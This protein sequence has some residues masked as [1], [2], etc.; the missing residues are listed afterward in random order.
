[1][2]KLVNLIRLFDIY[3]N[4]FQ[5]RINNQTKFKTLYGGLLSLVTFIILILC[6]LSFG[7]DFF[8]R[9]NPKVTLEEG[10]FQDDEI[11][12]LTGGDYP[13]KPGLI[14]VQKSFAD[15]AKLKISGRI[16]G[17]L[18]YKYLDECEASYVQT[19][20]A[21]IKYSTLS[22]QVLYCF[23]FNEFSFYG[24]E[25]ISIS[26]DECS[27]KSVAEEMGKRNVTCNGNV[28]ATTASMYLTLYTKQLGFK[29][30]LEKPFINK[31]VLYNLNF[32]NNAYS[33]ALINWNLQYLHDDVGWLIDSINEITDLNPQPEKVSLLTYPQGFRLPRFVVQFKLKDQYKRYNRTYI[34]LQDVLASLGG[35]MKLILT[36]LNLTSMLIRS[37]LIDLYIIDEKF[38]LD[39]KPIKGSDDMITRNVGN[40]ENSHNSKLV[41]NFL[42][43]H[44]NYID[45]I[46]LKPIKVPEVKT[47]SNISIFRYYRAVMMNYL[48][49]KVIGRRVETSMGLLRKKLK[50]VNTFQDYSY[51]LRKLN[52]FEVL[53]KVVLNEKQMLC[54]DFL[55]KPYSSDADPLLSQNFSSL[56]NSEQINK[57]S[58]INYYVK[59]LTEEPL[60]GYDEKMFKYLKDEVKED[61]MKK[62]NKQ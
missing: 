1:M 18:G 50:V 55:A 44:N 51:I 25:T 16:N 26:Y 29:P 36:L 33:T 19:Y 46:S 12:I 23:N 34:K 49:C 9:Q 3:G 39:K 60:G 42:E 38:E 15:Q 20:F 52:E 2:P 56:F 6:I 41:F 28:T 58:L 30:E 62:I 31:T 21:E 8:K 40:L 43:L 11:P 24:N 59:V 53:K 32:V 48:N 47:T 27:L 7:N 10:L 4:Y 37:Y 45:P 57:E 35:F 17:T 22:N 61:I 13:I 54:F 5:L 14:M